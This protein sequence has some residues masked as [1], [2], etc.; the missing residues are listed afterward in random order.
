MF[1]VTQAQLDKHNEL[2][3]RFKTEITFPDGYEVV[4]EDEAKSIS[5]T[6]GT[7]FIQI[8]PDGSSAS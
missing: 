1:K 2:N 7:I 4:P 3:A 6:Y 5:A 8:A